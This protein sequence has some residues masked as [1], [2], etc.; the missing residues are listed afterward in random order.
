MVCAEALRVQ[1]YFDGELDAS[2]SVDIER[3]LA[4][5]SACAALLQ[6]L[7]TIRDDVRLQARYHRAS[8][9]LKGAIAEALD[10]ESPSPAARTLASFVPRGKRFWSG[11]MSGAGMTA[12]AAAF[13]FLVLLPTPSDRVTG[14]LLSAHL[15]S[16]M[17][18]HLIDVASSDQHTVKP[19]FEG[20]ADVSPPANDFPKEDY[21]LV[22]G[23]VDYVDGRRAAVVPSTVG[24]D[25]CPPSSRAR[26]ITSSPGA[27]AMS[28]IVQCPTRRSTRSWVWSVSCR[29]RRH[30][31]VGNKP[32]APE[33]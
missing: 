25:R 16:L 1:S 27:M 6:D 28:L 10:G 14:D 5:C 12:L 24:T 23:R 29:R 4:A 7:Q 3:H 13:A 19:W 15:R 17:A 26:A 8:P 9:V 33:V 21:R 30:P 2:A 11:A 18:D 32:E 31:R 22:G 20:H